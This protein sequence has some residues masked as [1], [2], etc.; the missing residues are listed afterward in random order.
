MCGIERSIKHN[1]Q[2]VYHAPLTLSSFIPSLMTVVIDIHKVSAFHSQHI[3]R[4]ES[5]CTTPS[6][7]LP[8]S[9]SLSLSLPLPP[10]LS[11]SLTHTHLPLRP[12]VRCVWTGKRTVSSSVVTG[13]VSSVLTRSLSAQSVGNQSLR[14]SSSLTDSIF[15]CCLDFVYTKLCGIHLEKDSLYYL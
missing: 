15:H 4:L 9:P 6:L 14:R 7:P 1:S 12:S 2:L 13:H 8:P 10:S 11:L 3:L 5:H